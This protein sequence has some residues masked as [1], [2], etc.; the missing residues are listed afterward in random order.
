MQLVPYFGHWGSDQSCIFVNITQSIQT[1]TL[2]KLSNTVAMINKRIYDY[3]N[4]NLCFIFQGAIIGALPALLFGIL[5]LLAMV[6]T[7]T[8]IN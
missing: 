4:N 6:N 5:W 3:L 8:K 2:A 1:T 7:H